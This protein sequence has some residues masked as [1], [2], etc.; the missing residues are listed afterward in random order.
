MFGCQRQP[1]GMID[2]APAA[3]GATAAAAAA[4]AAVL[5]LILLFFTATLTRLC[6]GIQ[7]GQQ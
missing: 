6:T 5:I 1:A 7:G 4:A 3:A 2:A